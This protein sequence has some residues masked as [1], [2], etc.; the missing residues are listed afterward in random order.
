M[1]S[2]YTK[3][4]N[5]VL[6]NLCQTKLSSNQTM[7]LFAIIRRTLGF[8]K[9][10]NYVAQTEIAKMT[11]LDRRLVNRAIQE[12][13]KLDVIS[14]DGKYIGLSLRIYNSLASVE[15]TSA[16]TNDDKMPSAEMHIKEKINIKK[17]ASAETINNLREDL[18]KK[19][20]LRK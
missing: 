17:T 7:V 14:S 9:A 12:L 4:D 16:I 19:G 8:H 11:K 18:V 1:T 2:G 20:I 6:E 15:M 5:A 13:K 10:M 3:V